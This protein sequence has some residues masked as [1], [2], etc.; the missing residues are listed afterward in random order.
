MLIY[1]TRGRGRKQD[2][3]LVHLTGKG[4]V[5]PHKGHYHDAIVNKRNKTVAFIVEAY[6]AVGRR[7][8]AQAGLLAERAKG[9]G[10]TDRTKYGSTRVSTRSFYVHHMQQI[11]KAAV[12]YDAMAIRKQV[13]ALKQRIC[14]S[15]AQ[16]A[17]ASDV[18][19]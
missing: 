16:A 12:M 14:A 7:G 3:P 17:P 15:A 18:P 13:V 19:A 8:R 11:V 9:R 5:K 10:A 6:G 4:W 2:G 1:G